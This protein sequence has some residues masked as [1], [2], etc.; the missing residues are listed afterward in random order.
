MWVDN[1]SYYPDPSVIAG[2]EEPYIKASIL[3]PE[4]YIGPVMEL[5][6]ERRGAEH[7]RSTTSPSAGSS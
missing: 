6:R 3:M 1:P 5:C 2:A 4:R 7:R